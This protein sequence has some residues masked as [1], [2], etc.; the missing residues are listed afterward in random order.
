M[1]FWSLNFS[2]PTW[3]RLRPA[4]WYRW[5]RQPPSYI[6]CATLKNHPWYFLLLLE[7]NFQM[8]IAKCNQLIYHSYMFIE[9]WTIGQISI[10]HRK[11]KFFFVGVPDSKKVLKSTFSYLCNSFWR[12]TC[13]PRTTAPFK[14]FW[15]TF[16]HRVMN[17][18][19]KYTQGRL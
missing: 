1:G 9:R 12:R 17:Q 4:Q 13:L 7:M 15:P 16:S 11:T 2:V 18:G 3:Y 8:F 10:F 19:K 6:A 5:G 14:P